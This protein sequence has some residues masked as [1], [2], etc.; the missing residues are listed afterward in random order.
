MPKLSDFKPDEVRV[1]QP[2]ERPSG[3]PKLSDFKADEVKVIRKALD[4]PNPAD[5][6][7]ALAIPQKAIE[8]V[9]AGFADE[10][11]GGLK[12]R[13][14]LFSGK[15]GSVA[16]L[17]DVYEKERDSW[18]RESRNMRRVNPGTSAVSEIAGG[19]VG[20]GL[21]ARGANAA[22]PWLRAGIEGAVGGA[23]GS[24]SNSVLGVASDAATGGLAGVVLD[25]AFRAVA[26]TAREV[27]D[28]AAEK[29]VKASGAMTKQ[30][31]ELGNKGLLRDQGE[32]LLKNKV[33]T[34]GSSLEDIA[35]RAGAA[36]EKAGK[37]IGEVV[38][39]VDA[40]RGRAL[41]VADELVERGMAGAGAADRVAARK[42]LRDKIN[43][44][45]GYNFQNVAAGIRDL[46]KRDDQIG[47]AAFHRGKLEF[48]AD[49][50]DDIA[51]QGP[52]TLRTGLRNKTEQRRLL[53][54]V[55]SLGEDYKQEVY[56]II[57]RELDRAV[58]NTERLAAGVEK[59]A[60]PGAA[61]TGGAA[62]RG[63]GAPPQLPAGPTSDLAIRPPGEPRRAAGL[64][65][66]EA[67]ASDAL[68]RFKAANR[69]YAAAATA[70]KTANDRLGQVMANRDYGLTTAIAT[71]AGLVTGGAPGA[72]AMGTINNLARKYGSSVQ[73]DFA[74]KLG[75]LLE[76]QPEAFGKY[77]PD[78]R[79]AL[80]QGTQQFLI[81]NELVAKDDPKYA[82][83]LEQ[84]IK[85]D[86]DAQG[87][88]SAM[89]RRLGRE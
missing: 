76:R 25:K 80:R 8:G 55:D 79:N 87:K 69:E 23:G 54:D 22:R 73:A 88:G 84:I 29:A 12:A 78:L 63:A 67:G 19:A 14:A 62:V 59:M 68:S 5:Y 28:Y 33:V 82:A 65:E 39:N 50:F 40:L 37:T 60:A 57:S 43:A 53:K 81:A 3:Q 41:G 6:P 16:E 7:A 11:Y 15:V 86:A 21:A 51:K 66:I 47:A 42:A 89:S 70:E 61:K 10:M 85:N 35:E 13:D 45:F 20:G 72:V 74:W 38:D 34:A 64:D 71:N 31:R 24:E 2:T 4:L 9:T 26:P 1:V 52:G 17:R 36:R 46:A 44:E 18:R 27:K 75:T 48:L 77:G 58:A 30:F 83:F 32:W 56:D 49:V